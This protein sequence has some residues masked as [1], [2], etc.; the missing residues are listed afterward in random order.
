M[1]VTRK[2]AVIL[3]KNQ[4]MPTIGIAMLDTNFP[5]P[6]GDIGNPAS[7]RYPVLYE[8]VPQAS[9]R[10]ATSADGPDETLVAPFLTALNGLIDRGATV[11]GTS[12]GFLAPFQP[13]LSAQLN[14]PFIASSLLALPGL[15]RRYGGPQSVGVITY[16]AADLGEP[17]F[18]PL[19]VGLPP[20]VGLPTNGSL[21]TA[22]REDLPDL[23]MIAAEQEAVEAAHSLQRAASGKIRAILLECTNLGPYCGAITEAT[24]LP[25]FDS[26][27][28]LERQG[29][30]D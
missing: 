11:L 6:V 5:R 13:I 4:P 9:V 25:V 16:S 21:A 24:G 2:G 27:W 10:Q 12:C 20:L 3:S 29:A 28:S 7:F 8:T 17:H 19:E 14:R 1:T 22:I 26:V 15:Q 30:S 23:D 18:A